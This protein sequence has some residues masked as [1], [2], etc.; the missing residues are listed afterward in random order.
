MKK[1]YDKE[2]KNKKERE[3]KRDTANLLNKQSL[4][5]QKWTIHDSAVL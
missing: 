3:W 2:R 1:E 4:Y 5:S